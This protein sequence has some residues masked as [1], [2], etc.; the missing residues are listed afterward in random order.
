VVLDTGSNDLFPWASQSTVSFDRYSTC[1]PFASATARDLH[2]KLKLVYGNSSNTSTEQY[3]DTSGVS[4]LNVTPH[5][6]YRGCELEATKRADNVW[7]SVPVRIHIHSPSSSVNA[8]NAFKIAPC[9]VCMEQYNF[10][11][12]LFSLSTHL[13]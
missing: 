8:L 5:D 9:I 11:T 1:N 13:R 10:L 2:Q 4:G 7:I 3:S 6:I 12:F